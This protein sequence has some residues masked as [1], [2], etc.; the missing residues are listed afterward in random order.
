[1]SKTYTS[2]HQQ[3][4][5]VNAYFQAQSSYWKDLYEGNSLLSEI[6][7][8]RHAAIL[9]WI[10][11][12]AL[13]P[14]SQVLEIGCGA[15]FMAV[16]LAQRGLRVQAIDSVEAMVE[17]ADRNAVETGTANLLSITVGDAH[18]LAFDDD[19]FDLVL[20]IGVIPWLAQPEL[21][22]R[23]IARV[24]KP[25]GYAILATANRMAL[26][27]LLDPLYNP[28]LAP[29][30]QRVKRMLER[31]GPRRRPSD[32]SLSM[33][34]HN[35]R[36]IDDYLAS[37]ALVK[38]RGMTRGFQFWFLR[39]EVLPDPLSIALHQRLQRLVDR[40]ILGLRSLGLTYF[41]LTRKTDT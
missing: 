34:Y 32:Q 28:F 41:V 9:R 25:G 3:Q 13:A 15:G 39:R 7:R 1:V 17:Q 38:T 30:R 12:L 18:T 33:T 4:E 16:A 14:G 35:C 10:D 37:L 20:A 22:M 19:S 26:P 8:D 27:S 5:E 40:N 29:L 31:I 24:T 2:Y 11:S 6:V 36:F 23:E 21:A